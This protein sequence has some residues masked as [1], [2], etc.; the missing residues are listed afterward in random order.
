MKIPKA[1]FDKLSTAQ[2][3]ML[4]N[5]LMAT[6]AQQTSKPVPPAVDKFKDR[7]T[8][9]TRLDNILH[10][11][12]DT[13]AL[14]ATMTQLKFKPD[15]IAECCSLPVPTGKARKRPTLEERMDAQ[16]DADMLKGST[17]LQAAMEKE[18][19]K[20]APPVVKCK[21]CS[22][23]L[24]KGK[25]CKNKKECKARAAQAK[26]DA[27]KKPINPQPLKKATPN[28][29]TVAVEQSASPAVDR[30]QL[31]KAAEAEGR[32]LFNKLGLEPGRYCVHKD[33]GTAKFRGT[34]RAESVD[35]IQL[36]FK[37]GDKLFVPFVNADLI[38]RCE[39]KRKHVA[40]S[41][42]AKNA[43]G[44][45]LAE[46]VD[47]RIANRKATP[48][49][50]TAYAA[51]VLGK[52]REMIPE[53]SEGDD[54]YKS[55]SEIATAL[56]G[57][58]LVVCRSLDRLNELGLVKAEDDTPE[59]GH[60]FMYAYM[61]EAGYNFV[62]PSPEELA[63]KAPR[64]LPRDKTGPASPLSGKTIHILCKGNPRRPGTHG[65]TSFALVKEGMTYEAYKAAGGRNND[66][67]WDLDK[68]FVEMREGK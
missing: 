56:G 61:T 7:N 64:G 32:I 60:R 26:K 27:R 53:G 15:Q 25:T 57:S 36:E 18:D 23:P 16:T 52:V 43:R 46:Q 41:K 12:P 21:S 13:S 9:E 40:L 39:T 62:I 58:T 45:T 22:T 14:Q 38:S 11:F 20:D 47:K 65:H 29:A 8:A 28:G 49:R 66:L 50:I 3:T 35:V 68:G 6:I 51:L 33:Y 63:A 54:V 55:S 24:L 37:D 10:E 48:M 34:T 2:I 31:I 1:A 4:F 30:Y 5:A 19:R 42:L 59:N 17:A 67:Q 44:I